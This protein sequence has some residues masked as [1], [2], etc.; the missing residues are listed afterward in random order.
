MVELE[1]ANGS[2]YPEKGKIEAVTGQIDPA[3]GTIQFRASFSNAAK[4][5]SNG[6]S[7]NIRFP[8]YYNNAVV[9]PESST[10]E[11][12]GMVYVY[13]VGT[14]KK[15]K[16]NLI[17]VQ[18]RVNNLVIVKSGLQKGQTIVATGISGLKEGTD[19]IPKPINFD[20]LV[21]AIKPIF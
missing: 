12:Q 21:Q 5:L 18:G 9:V 3:T 15:V 7:G 19:I 10:Y 13:S 14:D 17:Q 16:N 11:Q 8:I 20:S 4:L 6:N 2:L 1:L